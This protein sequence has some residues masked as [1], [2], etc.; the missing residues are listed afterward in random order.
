MKQYLICILLFYSFYCNSQSLTDGYTD[1][2]SY[3]PG[4]TI[5]FYT[6]SNN[7]NPNSIISNITNLNDSN[8]VGN[9]NFI[10]NTQA[11][12][13]PYNIS[14]EYYKNGYEYSETGSWT[15]P[16][17][18][19]SGVYKIDAIKDIIFIVKKDT[20]LTSADVVIVNPTNTTYAYCFAGGK[21]LYY[22]NYI[23]DNANDSSNL[24]VSSN[25]GAQIVSMKR[26][27]RVSLES[28]SGDGFIKWTQNA[29]QFGNSSV[30]YISDVD[31]DN[32]NEINNSKLLI[33]IGHSEYW[34]REA[35]INL[36]QFVEN[37]GN[38]LIMSG[39][40]IWWQVRYNLQ[41]NLPY[42]NAEKQIICY[43]D[44]IIDPESNPLIKTIN[45]Y[46]K[47]LK[48]SI[49]GSIGVDFTK[50]LF[51]YNSPTE[52]PNSRFEGYKIMEQNSPIFL[53]TNFING[54]VL[55]F[56]TIEYDGL[57]TINNNP[58][59][60]SNLPPIIDNN[61]LGFYR[62][63]IF[64]YDIAKSPYYANNIGYTGLIAFQKNKNS[65]IVIN[66]SSNT[67]CN[68]VEFDH[69]STSLDKINLIKITQN[70]I[71]LLLSNNPSNVFTN[72]D[73]SDIFIVKPANGV[74]VSYEACSNGSIRITPGGIY[75]NNS[76]IIDKNNT[77]SRFVV[78]ST[79]C[80]NS[81]NYINSKPI[82]N[83]KKTISINENIE[84]VNLI[85]NPTKDF[86]FIDIKNDIIK[87]WIIFDI[88]GRTIKNGIEKKINISDLINGIYII[89]II[90][91]N[92]KVYRKKIIKI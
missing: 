72:V 74:N 28:E 44:E 37:G 12:I 17:N 66:T 83:I 67:W 10:A 62:S 20:I 7:N 79:P 42:N 24:S 57:L 87:N 30:S 50:A 47:K 92:G 9:V 40:S 61:G 6:R 70:M 2:V 38:V 19:N 63:Q 68:P 43:K 64:A 65:G 22:G 25:N 77:D 89:E 1:K 18:M 16:L 35:R 26:P 59:F 85:P 34:S 51:G 82:N 55:N 86:F 52:P 23:S 88:N 73:P 5:H 14:Q 56:K 81:S 75:L 8:I 13:N 32:Y 49:L 84:V 36:D 48:Y 27:I 3:V 54:D 45:W 91:E 41:S 31:M 46:D 60:N 90:S 53:G 4:E 58:N 76:Y 11:N 33:L 15:I 71:N 80:N 39:N 21:N 69:N 78:L 29:N